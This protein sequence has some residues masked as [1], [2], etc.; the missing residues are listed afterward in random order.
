MYRTGNGRGILTRTVNM[1]VGINHQ[2]TPS[3]GLTPRP[4]LRPVLAI[5]YSHVVSWLPVVN[6]GRVFIG[7]MLDARR[8]SGVLIERGGGPLNLP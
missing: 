3:G 5:Q 1:P 8:K 6:D 7:I 2:E 4:P